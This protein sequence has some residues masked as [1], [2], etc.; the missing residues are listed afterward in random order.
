MSEELTRCKHLRLYF[1]SGGYYIFCESCPRRWVAWKVGA[2]EYTADFNNADTDAG[3]DGLGR[4]DLRSLSQP[5]VTDAPK[6]NAVEEA[7]EKIAEIW[8]LGWALDKITDWEKVAEAL[9]EYA[10]S[11]AR[12]L[13]EALRA[14]GD[15]QIIAIN[16]DSDL[17]QA[18]EAWQEGIAMWKD[19]AEAAEAKLPK[20]V[21]VPKPSGKLADHYWDVRKRTM[22]VWDMRVDQFY[23]LTYT[24]PPLPEEK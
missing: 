4:D 3:G 8:Q 6:G 21:R 23:Q 20:W 10:L 7:E 12:R 17:T 1:G 16:K 14:V 18:R 22:T 9:E 19:R 11:L 2:A 15:A 5:V 24:L 13:D